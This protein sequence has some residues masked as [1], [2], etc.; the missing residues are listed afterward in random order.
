MSTSDAE[1]HFCVLFN[2]CLRSPDDELRLIC[3]YPD[4][5]CT[6]ITCTGRLP[7]WGRIL[8][9]IEPGMVI[10]LVATRATAADRSPTIAMGTVTPSLGESAVPTST[11][12]G[13]GFGWY[14]QTDADNFVPTTTHPPE[15]L[16]VVQS[17]L[18]E[19]P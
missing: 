4:N 13:G 14:S 11:F 1:F 19:D 5:A 12:T 16:Y 3:T 17:I 7:G 2:S 15:T 10:T 8:S 18:V 9:F 6:S